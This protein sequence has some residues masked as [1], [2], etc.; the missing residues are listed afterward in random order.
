MPTAQMRGRYMRLQKHYESIE[1]TMVTAQKIRTGFFI[2]A[3]ISGYTS[4]L[5]ETELEHAQEII[6]E[7][8]HDACSRWNYC[9]RYQWLKNYI[10]CQCN[11]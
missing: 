10:Q 11:C 4:F 9:R 8:I 7:I 1:Q 2:I 3:D 6:E 5:T